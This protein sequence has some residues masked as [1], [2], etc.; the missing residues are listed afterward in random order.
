MAQYIPHRVTADG[1]QVGQYGGILIVFY[2]TNFLSVPLYI[3]RYVNISMYRSTE[4]YLWSW[5]RKSSH[6]M[7]QLTRRSSLCAIFWRKTK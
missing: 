6:K 4:V 3:L 2:A 1:D 5:L 7:H